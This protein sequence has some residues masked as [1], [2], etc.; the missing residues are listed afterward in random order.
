MTSTFEILVNTTGNEWGETV[1]DERRIRIA[2]LPAPGTVD[3][4]KVVE[5]V[6]DIIKPVQVCYT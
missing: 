2:S 1:S 5:D 4:N 6:E 3:F